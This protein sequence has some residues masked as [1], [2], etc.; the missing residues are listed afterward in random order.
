METTPS[1]DLSGVVTA[2]YRTSSSVS[3]LP[4]GD[5]A[6]RHPLSFLVVDDDQVSLKLIVTMMRSLG[7]EPSSACNGLEAVGVYEKELPGCIFMD[8]QMPVM[9]GIEAVKKIREIE[10]ASALRPAFIVAVTANTLPEGQ[11]RCIAA[12]MNLYLHKPVQ[13]GV[14]ADTLAAAE[15]F[16]TN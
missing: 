7:Y 16:R 9:G 12:G 10:T 6:A 1:P 15:K 13:I 8:V 4:G 11:Q 5:F 14:V 3:S 2:T